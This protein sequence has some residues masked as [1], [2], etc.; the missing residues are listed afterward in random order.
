MHMY[1]GLDGTST[2]Q[3]LMV[4]EI[5]AGTNRTV[6]LSIHQPRPEVFHMFDKL[7]LISEG[8][9]YTCSVVR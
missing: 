6:V 3:F 7:V 5:L 9:V 2:L 8:Q 1:T 4:L